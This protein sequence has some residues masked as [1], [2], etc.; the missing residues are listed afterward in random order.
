MSGAEAKLFN[1]IEVNGVSVSPG[2]GVDGSIEF[3]GEGG[4]GSP[5]RWSVLRA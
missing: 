1:K 5:L 4:Q 2:P 3:E